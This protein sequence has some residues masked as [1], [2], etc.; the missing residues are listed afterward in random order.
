MLYKMAISSARQR[1]IAYTIGRDETIEADNVVRGG[2][3]VYKL[4]GDAEEFIPQQRIV[5]SKVYL[6]VQNQVPTAG[7][8]D[9]FLTPDSILAKYAF[10]YDRRESNLAYI[11]SSQLL[12]I[13]PANM[14]V[15]TDQAK[16][17]FEEVVSDRSRG[18]VLWR[19]CLVLALLALAG[20]TLLLKFWKE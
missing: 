17:D 3:S 1:P 5:T 11:P 6:G 20:E 7:Y 8:Y 14:S 19:W 18:V 10:N 13:V 15:I 16:A 9:L 4:K 12:E 2:E